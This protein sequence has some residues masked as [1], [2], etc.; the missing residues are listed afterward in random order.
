MQ[1]PQIS[2][3]PDGKRLH[4]HH[5]PIDM[6]VDVEG[7]G[8]VDALRIAVA[9]FETLL[10]ELVDDLPRLRAP[11]GPSPHSETGK[12]MV[13]ATDPFASDFITPMAA[14][15]GAGADKILKAI[16][17]AAEV[18]KAY[19]NNGGDIAFHLA[20]G[21]TLT[22]LLASEPMAKT[23]IEA[24][25]PSRGI[26]TSG[27][28]GRSQSLGIADTV[29]VLATNAAAADAAA[30]M[31][32]NS[33]DLPGHPSVLRQAA[34]EISPDSDLR[35]RE[36]TIRVGTLSVPDID[37]ALACGIC[38]ADGLL[39]SGLIHGAYLA[40]QG[41]FRTLGALPLSQQKVLQNA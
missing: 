39:K 5:G 25:Q 23:V 40:L 12:A 8:R 18:T 29:T 41:Q 10:Q 32:A 9:R 17:D 20:A 38:Y 36:V 11:S 28:R 16:C 22:A 19:V 6:I 30:T 34:C 26:A 15:A 1:G 21:Q 33:V 2:F 31:I 13:R 24:A 14:V 35:D 4:L 7:P 27:W 3:L 37:R